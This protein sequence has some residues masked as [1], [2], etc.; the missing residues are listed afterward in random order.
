MANLGYIQLKANPGAWILQL[1]HGK[2][3]DIYD[4]T[5]A[6]GPNTKHSVDS[7]RVVVSSLKSHVLKLRVT[8]KP[9]MQQADLLGDDSAA[10]SGIWNSITSTITGASDSADDETL[11]IF[12]GN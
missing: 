3:S 4:I 12:T 1:R 7:T 8:K 9:G 2:S 5:S 11:N 6:E 10:S